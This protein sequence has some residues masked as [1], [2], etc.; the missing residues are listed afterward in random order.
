MIFIDMID[1][2]DIGLY[3]VILSCNL[4]EQ[5]VS[6]VRYKILVYSKK[7]L[8]CHRNQVNIGD[9]LPNKKSVG[10]I[11]ELTSL[12]ILIFVE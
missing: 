8:F 5:Y 10:L 9:K 12:Q 2:G 1:I 3:R 4:L 7:K 6:I 11:P